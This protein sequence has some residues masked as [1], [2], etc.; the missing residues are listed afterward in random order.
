MNKINTSPDFKIL[1]CLR[2]IAALYVVI[3]H[4][5]GNLFMGGSELAEIIPISEWS[6]WTKLHYALLQ[7][8]SLG[9]EFVVFFFV[10]SG[11]SIAFSLSRKQKIPL[12]YLKR[13][14][15]LYPPYILALCWAAFAFYIFSIYQPEFNLNDYSVFATLKST[16][17]NLIYVYNGAYIPQFWSLIHE[18]IFYILAPILIV[19]RRYY[20]IISI[21]FY[22]YGWFY[23]WNSLTGG[24]ILTKFLFDYNIYFTIGIW[25]FFNYDL[26]KKYVTVN[27]LKTY[28]IFIG[29][30]SI[31]V[32]VKFMTSDYNKITPLLASILS[33]FLIINFQKNKIYSRILL[34][35]GATSYTL[36]ISHY[37]TL[38]LYHMLLVKLSLV[39][40]GIKI[41]N[42][43][44][45]MIG[46]VICVLVSYVFYLLAERPSKIFIEKLRNKKIK[47]SDKKLI[48]NKGD[49][50]GI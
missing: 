20:Y 48:V 4:S 1:D 13:L 32:F 42:P 3:N 22:L 26:V 17:L 16:L 50:I 6:I 49:N 37:A 15:R 24:S 33:I 23:N 28:I 8:T 31:M 25:L 44:Y 40:E 39:D 19:R 11:F 18:V 10:L 43:I 12:F 46:V 35:L 30:V 29:L 41:T 7:F 5:R 27:K 14:I 2:G 47:P 45:W 9:T 21:L 34:F 38:K 36:Y